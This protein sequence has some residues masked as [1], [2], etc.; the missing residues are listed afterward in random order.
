MK[1][2]HGGKG[3]KSAEGGWLQHLA[4]C[5]K[6]VSQGEHQGSSML[7]R[8]DRLWSTGKQVCPNPPCYSALP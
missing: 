3:V 2:R 6:G 4:I 7:L 5:A 1:V 8:T